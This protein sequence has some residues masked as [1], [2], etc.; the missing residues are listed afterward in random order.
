MVSQ[1]SMMLNLISNSHITSPV[2][3][4]GVL[5]GN[6]A[7]FLNYSSTLLLVFLAFF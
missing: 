3:G 2:I 7:E 1:K 4:L 5:V 6:P